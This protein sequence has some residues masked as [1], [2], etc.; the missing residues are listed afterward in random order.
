MNPAEGTKRIYR[1]HDESFQTL[2][3]PSE[4]E[5]AQGESLQM[6]GAPSES[7]WPQGESL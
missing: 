7:V 6:L 3:A 2:G 1:A 5:R 4:P